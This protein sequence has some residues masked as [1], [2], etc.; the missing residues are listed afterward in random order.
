M[1]KDYR[2][3]YWEESVQCSFDEVGL[4]ATETQIQAVAGDMEVCAEQQGMAFG[5]DVASANQAGEREREL[6]ALRSQKDAEIDELRAR[7]NKAFDDLASSKN[8]T[9]R[10]LRERLEEARNA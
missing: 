7:S 8:R 5:S 6:K 9:I 10:A 1:A 2:R 3:E 4:V